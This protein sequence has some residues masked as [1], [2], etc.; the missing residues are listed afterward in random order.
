MTP[1]GI[2]IFTGE[3]QQPNKVLS[4]GFHYILLINETLTFLLLH[5][6]IKT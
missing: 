4:Q 2:C 1:H 3:R 5:K 6:D